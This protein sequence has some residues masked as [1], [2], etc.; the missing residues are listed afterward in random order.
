[1]TTTDLYILNKKSTRWVAE[2]VNGWGSVPC[3][4]DHM[5]YKYYPNANFTRHGD[6]D[7]ISRDDMNQMVWNL[8][9]DDQVTTEERVALM[10][11]F[12]RSY[13][14]ITYLKVA[15]EACVTAAKMIDDAGFWKGVNHWK[16]IGEKL[17]ELSSM[18]F[19]HQARGVVM[20]GSSVCDWWNDPN[21]DYLENAWPIIQGQSK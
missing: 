10:M 17:I 18:N 11:T 4:W 12:D 6:P 21:T 14:P 8:A 15:G 5:A 3:I 20:N 2:F 7:Y 13:V 19:H 1:M 16:A 9:S